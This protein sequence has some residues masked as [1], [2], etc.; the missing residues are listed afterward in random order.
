MKQFIVL[1]AVLPL[2]LIFLVQFSEEQVYG[3]KTAAIEDTVYTAREMAK[4][5]G[6]F[7]ARVVK[8]LKEELCRKIK[9]LKAEEIIIGPG[10]DTSPV[11]RSGTGRGRGLIYV[12]IR[13]A[14]DPPGAGLSLLGLRKSD[15]KQYYVVEG[16]T[17]SERLP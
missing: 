11:Y 15:K 5:D 3:M 2:L 12:R 10:T 16:Y 4:Q 9:G 7:S 17:P 8:W 6:C 13:V 1:A 14:I